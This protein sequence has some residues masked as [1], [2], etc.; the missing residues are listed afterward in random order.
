MIFFMITGIKKKKGCLFEQPFFTTK[1]L[2][3]FF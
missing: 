2:T 1:Q 3:N